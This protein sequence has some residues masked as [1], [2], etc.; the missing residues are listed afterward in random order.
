MTV[1]SFVRGCMVALAGFMAL[2]GSAGAQDIP[3]GKD[4]PAVKRF[5]GSVLVG[6]EVRNFD[7]VEFQTSTFKEF[8]LDASTRRYV[9]PPLQLEGK[10][11]RLWYEAAGET[12][13]LELYRNYVNELTASGFK[14]VYDSTKDPAA[15]KWT[16]FLASFSASKK[17]FIK[18]NRSEYVM[19]AAETNSL[20]TGTFQ[21][22]NVTVR[23]VSIDW[24]KADQT[25]KSR[26]GA[27][28]AVDILETKAMQQN[29]VV[30]S[31]SE[32]G[33]S[34]TATGKVAIYGIYFDTGKADVK[35]ESRPSLDQIAA[36]LKAESGVKLHVV[37]HTDSVGG[38]DSNM[39]LS[40]RRADAVISALVK[41]YGVAAS[42][43]VGNGVASLAPVASNSNE[44]GRAKNRRV[45]LVLQ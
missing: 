38:F 35:P 26:Q 20:R 11:T 16:N 24:S 27:Y 30:V 7:A 14:A 12:R 43:M 25:Y 32:I 6:Y 37:G 22:D 9:Q 23:L 4:H 19:Y 33:K 5:G 34:I 8:D 17:D 28:I 41:D 42:R 3:G 31:A 13:S 15:G 18:N 1:T 2:L 39:T 45:E 29:M 36:F 10:L 44:D 40:K 21:K